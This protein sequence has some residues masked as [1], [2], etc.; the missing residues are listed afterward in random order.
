[1]PKLAADDGWTVN[2]TNEKPR[3]GRFS[4]VI[5]RTQTDAPQVFGN[6]MQRIDATPWRGKRIL[7]R[8]AVRAEVARTGEQA[9]MWLRV[10]RPGG[11]MGFFDNMGAR[12]IRDPE[13]RVYEISGDVAEDANAIAFGVMLIG[14]GKAFVDDVSLSKVPDK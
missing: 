4:A 13:W 7:L 6:V 10:D 3:E 9:Q 11:K 12:P 14:G 1:V 2:V 8:A 5:S